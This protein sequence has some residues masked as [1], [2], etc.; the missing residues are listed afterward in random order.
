[1]KVRMTATVQFKWN[2]THINGRVH[3]RL[4]QFR[5]SQKSFIHSFGKFLIIIIPRFVCRLCTRRVFFV[6]LFF[7]FILFFFTVF[8]IF[9]SILCGSAE[10]QVVLRSQFPIHC[11]HHIELSSSSSVNIWNKNKHFILALSDCLS[12]ESGAKVANLYW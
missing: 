10:F 9:I 3:F 5:D 4:Y 12:S 11:Q 1:M 8:V 6:C 7:D 2:S